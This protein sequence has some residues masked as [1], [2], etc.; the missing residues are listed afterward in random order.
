MIVSDAP[1][2]GVTYDC[3]YDDRNS[4]IIQATGNKPQLIV[5]NL[6]R[7]FELRNVS[8]ITQRLEAKRVSLELAQTGS[9]FPSPYVTIP[10]L[11]NRRMEKCTKPLSGATTLAL[12][13]NPPNATST[14]F[15]TVAYFINILHA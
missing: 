9:R 7:S 1:N 14:E 11:E 6:G 13:D 2:C 8:A 12:G 10:G 3:H 5:Q 4:F 15:T